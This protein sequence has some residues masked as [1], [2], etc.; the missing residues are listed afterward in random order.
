MTMKRTSLDFAEALLPERGCGPQ[1]RLSGRHE[2]GPTGQ[3]RKRWTTHWKPALQALDIAFRRPTLRRPPQ[4]HTTRVTPLAGQIHPAVSAGGVQERV[5][6]AERVGHPQFDAG[7]MGAVQ[8][9]RCRSLFRAMLPEAGTSSRAYLR[10]VSGANHPL[11]SNTPF[12]S[13]YW[14]S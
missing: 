6:P 7:G 3:G 2:P 14:P 1:V 10:V 11:R 8:P 5:A 9:A 4:T 13:R 12:T